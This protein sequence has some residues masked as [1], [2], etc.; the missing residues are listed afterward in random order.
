[1]VREIRLY[2][3]LGRRFGRV[4]RYDVNSPGEA[5]RALRANYGRKWER[6]MFDQRDAPFRLLLDDQIIDLE[7]M[8]QPMGPEVLKIVPVICGG[9]NAVWGIV[10]GVA[11]IALAGPIGGFIGGPAMLG[12]GAATITS[13]IAAV[14]LGLALMG[15]S[16][17][18]FKPPKIQTTEPTQNQPSY[19]FAN[20]AV[21]TVGQGNP[22]P[23]GYGRVFAGSQTISFGLFAEDF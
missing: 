2:G 19:S 1:M 17:L 23:V 3:D 21:N 6:Y 22:V 18:L 11:L 8:V 20:G 5:L 7:R 9:K 14:G 16:Q 15:V 12:F 10:I 13:A 4:H